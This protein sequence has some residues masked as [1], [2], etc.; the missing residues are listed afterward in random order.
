MINKIT[1]TPCLPRH[2]VCLGR[3]LDTVSFCAVEEFPHSNQEESKTI[4]TRLGDIFYYRMASVQE[5][6][7][8]GNYQYIFI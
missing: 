8:R 3:I 5:K 1:K 6:Q 2:I 4:K 7:W